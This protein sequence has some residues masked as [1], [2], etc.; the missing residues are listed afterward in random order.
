MTG[1]SP[2]LVKS[3]SLRCSLSLSRFKQYELRN[4]STI[5]G[6]I[7][8][9]LSQTLACS[10][11][12]HRSHSIYPEIRCPIV[13]EFSNQ[14]LLSLSTPRL[15]IHF[16]AVHGAPVCLLLLRFKT[17]I[18]FRH[19]RQSDYPLYHQTLTLCL[20]QVDRHASTA[21]SA[22][23]KPYSISNKSLARSGFSSSVLVSVQ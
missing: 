2:C 16:T 14:T 1:P 17:A 15:V 9:T 11:A 22:T 23:W 13:M 6:G 12:R 18:I 3:T 20:I 19:G 10:E 7:P 4:Q 21:T 5:C 8:L